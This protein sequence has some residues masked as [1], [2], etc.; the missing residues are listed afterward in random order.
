M[1]F[2]WNY[3]ETMR[4][5]ATDSPSGIQYTYIDA[6]D[7]QA[8]SLMLKFDA[9]CKGCEFPT[10]AVGR[11]DQFNPENIDDSATFILPLSISA[12][13]RTASGADTILKH[14]IRANDSRLNKV[15]TPKG[16]TY[17]GNGGLVLD[18]DLN[19]LLV[20]NVFLVYN[21]ELHRFERSH[22][23]IHF[24]PTV[25][26]DD[27]KLL[28]K[29]LAKKGIAYYLTHNTNSYRGTGLPYKVVIGGCSDFF[30]RA[31]K[32]DVNN[33]TDKELNQVLKDNIDEVLRQIAN[34]AGR[35]FF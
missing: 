20:S 18:K 23:V 35:N 21:Q 12:T 3:E 15:V 27:T 11:L 24:S 28:N 9:N 26:T 10:F 5:L 32:P 2:S 29:A 8:F 34:D 25:F 31:H 13:S 16:E 33:C 14:F 7:A 1:E 19:P 30:V 22:Y 6:R 17:Y 4:H